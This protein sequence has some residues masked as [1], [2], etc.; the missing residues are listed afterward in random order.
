MKLGGRE[1][2]L[3]LGCSSAG[4]PAFWR[5]V[6]RRCEACSRYGLALRAWNA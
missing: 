2:E 1:S 3:N 5:P 4:V 6:G